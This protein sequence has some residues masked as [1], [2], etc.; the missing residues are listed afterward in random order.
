MRPLRLPL[1]PRCGAEN[2][3]AAAG[4]KCRSCPGGEIFF[5]AVRSFTVYEGP[6]VAILER[7]KYRARPQYADY[8]APLMVRALKSLYR[9]VAFDAMIPVPLHRT[10]QRER[11]YNQAELIAR[12]M[13]RATG[14]PLLANAIRRVRPTPSQTHL[15]RRA[16]A[17]NVRDAF[18]VSD[19]ALIAGKTL[20][21]IDDVCTTC[22]TLNECARVLRASGAEMVCGLTFCRASLD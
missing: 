1:C 6:A 12:S 15:D 14:I 7:L 13:T 19:P 9:D 2:S 22:A 10:R 17:K 21:M 3:P 5:Q 4:E 11:G 18:L 16:R 8:L 20:L